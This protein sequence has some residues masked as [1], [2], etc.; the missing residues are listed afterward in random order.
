MCPALVGVEWDDLR[1]TGKPLGAVAGA[2]VLRGTRQ[3][4]LQQSLPAGPGAC[5]SGAA[6]AS[7]RQGSGI[8]CPLKEKVTKKDTM[9]KKERKK[10]TKL[11]GQGGGEGGLPQRLPTRPSSPCAVRP[12]A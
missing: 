7:A 11:L 5:Q 12:W 3:A 2:A 8:K 10:D 9:L 4:G 6:L 1:D